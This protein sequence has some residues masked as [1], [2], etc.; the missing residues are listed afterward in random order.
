MTRNPPGDHVA[1]RRLIEDTDQPVVIP[2]PVLVEVD[3]WIHARLHPGV[4]VGAGPPLDSP[5]TMAE[6]ARGAN[7]SRAGRR[8][9]RPR[10][11]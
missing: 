3:Y 6:P 8:L 5:E 1:C 9:T 11:D 2:A 7:R 4:L 10:R